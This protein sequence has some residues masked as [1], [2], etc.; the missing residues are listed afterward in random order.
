[1]YNIRLYYIV[2]TLLI[3]HWHRASASNKSDTTIKSRSVCRRWHD[4]AHIVDIFLQKTGCSDDR[5]Y[6]AM[7]AV[8][9]TYCELAVTLFFSISAYLSIVYPTGDLSMRLYGLLCLLIEIHI[10]AFIAVRFYHRPQ[11]RDMYQRS[12]K[13]GIPEDCRRKIAMVIKHHLVVA[14]VFVSVSLLYTI[15]LD[16][17]QMGDPFTF[18]FVDVLPTK[19]TNA[20]VYVCKYILY[21]LPVYFAHLEICFL[22]V[23]F[24]YSTGV[25]KRHFQILDEQVEE[26]I[27]NEDEQKLKMAIKRH[28]E[29][30]KW[31]VFDALGVHYT[32]YTVA[33]KT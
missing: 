14:N 20:T 27:A 9:F 18:P 15:S 26:A 2:V 1:L 10:F 3:F 8:Y 29:V 24:M 31:V 32:R 30:L 12:R 25:V 5:G 6:D 23:T 13:M 33:F 21:V 4:M 19:T 22:N 28:Q 7:R 17:V 16:W 11:F